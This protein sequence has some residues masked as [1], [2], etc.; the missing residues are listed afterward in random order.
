[1]AINPKQKEFFDQH[2]EKWDEITIHDQSKV[3]HIIS[4]LELKGD[5]KILDVGT[6]TGVTI[7]FYEPLL[8]NGSVLGIDYSDKMIEVAR[9]K[10]PASRHPKVSFEVGNLYDRKE[11]SLYDRVVC[12]SCFPHFPDKEGALIVLSKTLKAGGLLMVSH[13]CS[14]DRINKVHREGGEVIEHDYLPKM[15]EMENL[16]AQAG[17]RK[18]ASRD[19]D[20]YYYIIGMKP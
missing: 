6:G 4:L 7:P 15:P 8:K 11:C 13:S 18:V 14:R 5:E 10:F 12:Y 17:L 2:A 16:F 20:D 9:G 19:D 3:R 1:M